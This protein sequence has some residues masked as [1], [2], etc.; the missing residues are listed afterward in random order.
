MKGRGVRGQ[1]C[2]GDRRE[3]QGMEARGVI[4]GGGRV[5][6]KGPKKQ[7]INAIMPVGSASVPSDHLCV[8]ILNTTLMFH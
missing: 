1:G 5:G 4:V 8:S 7:G 3:W 6:P 2:G